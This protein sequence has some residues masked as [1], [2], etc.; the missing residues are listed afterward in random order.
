MLCVCR[1]KKGSHGTIPEES[2]C[3]SEEAPDD[4]FLNNNGASTGA[5]KTLI[6]NAEIETTFTAAKPDQVLHIKVKNRYYL[7][8]LR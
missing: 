6:I 1:F 2:G 7:N 3:G 5:R 8:Q 4:G